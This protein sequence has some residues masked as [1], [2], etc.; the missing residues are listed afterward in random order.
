MGIPVTTYEN[1]ISSLTLRN[2]VLHFDFGI[3]GPQNLAKSEYQFGLS[4]IM[5]PKTFIG[6]PRNIEYLTGR[7]YN[8]I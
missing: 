4:S 3:L 2:G 5:I 1:F 8:V 6:V 7:S